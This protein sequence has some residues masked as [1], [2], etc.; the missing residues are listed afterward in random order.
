MV[1][2][3]VPKPGVDKETFAKWRAEAS[4]VMH[5]CGMSGY[6]C[7][8]GTIIKK[9]AALALNSGR[10]DTYMRNC[11]TGAYWWILGNLAAG[12]TRQDITNIPAKFG[13]D[14]VA[15]SL[16]LNHRHQDVLNAMRS[17]GLEI[18][19][20]V[21]REPED[22]FEFFSWSFKKDESG[23]VTWTP[24]RFSKHIEAFLNSPHSVR[25][26][27][28]VAHMTNW[29]HSEDHYNF[30]RDVYL[31]SHQSDGTQYP[32]ERIPDRSNLL[33][34]LSGYESLVNDGGKAADCASLALRFFEQEL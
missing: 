27:S 10:F 19:K 6:H 13:G 2:L 26:E 5:R 24:T 28:L 7:A 21:L 16:P 1:G 11:I 4:D 12:Y 29:V 22:G 20:D 33:Y 9:N 30:W 18:H 14:D 23:M 3:A 34:H 25:Q 17:F 15:V 31:K 32:L 8:D